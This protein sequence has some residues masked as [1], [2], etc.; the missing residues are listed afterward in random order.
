[1]ELPPD[2][3]NKIDTLITQCKNLT[4]AQIKTRAYLTDPMKS[5]L[6][7]QKSG[8][9]MANHPVFDGWITPKSD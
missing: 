9:K 7:R 3:A 1:M 8:E 6:R 4:D 2:V 5:I